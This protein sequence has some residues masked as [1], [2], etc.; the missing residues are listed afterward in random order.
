MKGVMTLD[1]VL[2]HPGAMGAKTIPNQHGRTIELA[3]ETSQELD[4][5]L[6]IDARVGVEAKVQ[7]DSV[8]A[9]RY[10]ET[11]NG[12]DF[13]VRTG[14]LMQHRGLPLRTP[15]AS[16]QGGIIKPLSSIKTSQAFRREA[17]F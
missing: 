7:M 6:G 16:D 3:Q 8:T 2:R 17:F 5:T 12:G 4:D 14:S 1:E 13:F 10:A 11:G 9:W 15:G